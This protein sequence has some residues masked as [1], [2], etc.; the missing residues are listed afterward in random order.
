M[1]RTYEYNGYTIVDNGGRWL[2]YGSDGRTFEA[3]TDTDI[4]EMIDSR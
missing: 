3:S 4:E 2:A 1:N